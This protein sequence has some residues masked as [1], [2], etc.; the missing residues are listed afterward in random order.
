MRF[1]VAVLILSP[2]FGQTAPDAATLIKQSKDALAGYRSYQI[3]QDMSMDLGAAS[4]MAG[5]T[6]TMTS[7]IV[8]PNKLR[9]EMKTAGIDA[10]LTVSDGTNAWMYM[11]MFKQYAKVPAESPDMHEMMDGFGMSP[12]LSEIDGN[13]A[14]VTGSEVLEVDGQPHDCWVIESPLDKAS[15][16]GPAQMTDVVYRFWIDK[17]FGFE[18]KMTMSGKT[19]V[20]NSAPTS[21]RTVT[22][23]RSLKLN[24]DLPDSLF[25]FTPPADAKENSD[26]INGMGAIAGGAPDQEEPKTAAEKSV[27]PGEPE[28]FVPLLH[29]IEYIEPAYPPEAQAKGVQGTVNVLVTVDSTGAVVHQEP[30]SGPAELRGAAMDVVQKWRFHPLYRNGHPVAAYTTEMVDFLIPGSKRTPADLNMNLSEEMAATQKTQDLNARFPRSPEQVLA[31]SEDQIRDADTESR[32]YELADIAREAMDAGAVEK[33]SS[34]AT[35]LLKMAA[36]DQ[37]DWNYGNAVFTGNM[38]LGLVALRQ[39]SVG[40][41]RLYLLESAKTKGS[42]QLDS[43]GPDFTL[44]R[45]LL[46]QGERDAVLD[47]LAA[48]KSFWTLGGDRLDQMIAA[49]KSGDTF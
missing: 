5:F 22:T 38:V 14:K 16:E 30:L 39:G 19:K 18:L 47:F 48:C 35:E 9:M 11:P 34:Y 1:A 10:A 37:D 25:V 36:D 8:N 41:A 27:Q 6:M 32:F 3:V 13:R 20:G 17:T 28:A 2:A 4:P 12:G 26:L 31:D 43:F 45:A 46:R 15:G 40:Q 29:P 24:V 23:T 21:T 49:V 42:P 7:S 44:A 33:A